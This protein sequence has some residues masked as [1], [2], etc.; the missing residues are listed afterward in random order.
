M[1]SNPKIPTAPR[2][3]IGKLSKRIP[4]L[5]LPIV[6][7]KEKTSTMSWDD[8]VAVK[9]GSNIDSRTENILKSAQL[10]QAPMLGS[11]NMIHGLAESSSQLGNQN[12][13][14]NNELWDGEYHALSLSGY[15][16]HLETDTKILFTSLKCLTSF[17]KQHPL[18]G[19]PIEQFPTILGVGSYVWNLL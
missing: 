10:L 8:Q 7:P 12:I 3:V 13:A 1:S 17:I 18:G 14:H 2:V 11:L 9:E 16:R 4:L 19:C 15:S 6:F 5:K